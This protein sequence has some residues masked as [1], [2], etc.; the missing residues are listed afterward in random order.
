LTIFTKGLAFF[1][2]RKSFGLKPENNHLDMY[3]KSPGTH[4]ARHLVS[5]R[6]GTNAFDLAHIFLGKPIV[7]FVDSPILHGLQANLLL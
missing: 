4:F 5:F 7:L 1:H 6:H 3:H 2:H